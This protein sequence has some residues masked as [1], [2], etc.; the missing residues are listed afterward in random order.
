MGIGSMA[1]TRGGEN[2]A[3]KN[4]LT[5]LLEAR[6]TGSVKKKTYKSQA[7]PKKKLCEPG[8]PGVVTSN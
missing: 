5:C 6:L 2:F 8:N 7:G 4:V 1:K 3:I